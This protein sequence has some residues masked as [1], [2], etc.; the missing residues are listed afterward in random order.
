M[1]PS[2]WPYPIRIAMKQPLTQIAILYLAGTFLVGA[3]TGAAVGY[4][5]HRQPIS[6]WK[7][8]PPEDMSNRL[9]ERVSKDLQLDSSQRDKF[10]P[11]FADLTKEMGKVHRDG[12]RQVQGAINRF[13]DRIRPDLRPDQLLRLEQK[14]R[15]L[16]LRCSRDSKPQSQLQLQAPQ[17]S[18]RRP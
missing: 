16:E 1:T 9:E 5:W 17:N 3:V 12:M 11:L 14:E 8:R 4:S 6:P 2:N 7:G 18:T 15:E 10:R 13:H